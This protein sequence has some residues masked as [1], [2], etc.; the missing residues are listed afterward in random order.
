MC[1]TEKG[2]V[3]IT[4][5]ADQRKSDASKPGEVGARPVRVVPA[6]GRDAEL[7]IIGNY[8]RILRIM[9]LEC[10]VIFRIIGN[11][12]RVLESQVSSVQSSSSETV[13]PRSQGDVPRNMDLPVSAVPGK[14]WRA[15][16]PCHR[17]LPREHR[18]FQ[19][20][21][22]AGGVAR[23]LGLRRWDALEAIPGPY[24]QRVHRHLHRNL[25]CR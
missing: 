20:V 11:P 2:H 13:H 15:L 10:A 14:R 19:T 21:V 7:R 25:T 8:S 1:C 17:R 4:D 18:A 22:R 6:A 16:H 5:A 12:K 9:S 23:S 3:E 24:M